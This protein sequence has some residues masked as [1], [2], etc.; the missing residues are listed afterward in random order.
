[1]IGEIIQE[2]LVGLGVTIDKPGF[3]QLN[4]TINEASSTIHTATGSWSTDFLKASTIIATALASVTTAAA[5]VMKATA[6]QD[7]AMEKLARRMM[8]SKDAAWEMKEATDA[9]GESVSDIIITPELMERYQKLVADGRNMKVGGDFAATMRGFRDL[10]FEFTR[11]KQEV[12]YALTWVGYYLL[13]YLNRP[14]A[15]AQARFRSFND[16]FIRN[17]AAWTEKLA[18]AAVY[19]INIGLHFFDLI[20]S[21]TSS[22]YDMWAAFPKGI[23]IATAAIAAF[24]AV[25]KMSPLGRMITLVSTL[26]LLVDD[27]FGYFE[28]KQA[29][30]GKYWDMLSAGLAK[31]KQMVIELSSAMGDI[32][33]DIRSSDTFQ[34]FVDVIIR[35]GKALYTLGSGGISTVVKSVRMLIDALE[36]HEA[37]KKFANVL[38]RLGRIISWLTRAVQRNTEVLDGWLGELEQSETVKDFFDAVS[39]LVSAVLDLADALLELVYTALRAFFGSMDTTEPVYGF[40]DAVRA[41]VKIITMMV[42]VLSFVIKLLAKFF[43][44]MASN[45]LFRDFWD[46]LGR[47]VKTFGSIIDTVVEGAIKRLGKLG[48]ALACLV[49]GDF[50]GAKAALF[51]GSGTTTPGVGNAGESAAEMAEYL[52]ANGIPVTAAIGIMGNIGGESSYDPSA[53]NSNDS[54]GYPSGGLAQWHADRFDRLQDFAANRGTNW[55]DRKTQLD[56]LIYELQTDYA[57]VLE[58]M[59]NASS[60]EEATEIFLR[61]FEKPRYPDDVLPER[62]DNAREV[63]EEVKRRANMPKPKLPS[64]EG[65]SIYPSYP[66]DPYTEILPTPSIG[67]GMGLVSMARYA[68]R[69]LQRMVSQA[70]PVLLN[71]IGSGMYPARYGASSHNVTYRVDVGGVTVAQTNASP[72]QIGNAVAEASMQ[73]LQQRGQYLLQN[74]TLT[75]GPNVV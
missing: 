74:R 8:V 43:K 3:Q 48:R 69:G 37:A 28:G 6:G 19:I 52:I 26:L 71:G 30:F 7:L 60:I 64:I 67:G 54:D 65:T 42:R 73:A 27:Y 4:A 51:G 32:A 18:R 68:R 12:S 41:V 17:M 20:K 40:R 66:D 38:E 45:Q 39:E 1:M 24:F 23:K 62:I 29:L 70:D 56:Y 16:S 58:Q 44:M 21:I 25:L 59:K 36:R 49:K 63:A 50:E 34:I 57:D 14:L 9:L 15:E 22:I 35:L 10:M 13:K 2:Y 33:D 47:A 46:G 72:Q 11:L 5:G 75:G 61:G 53:Y 55:R 31:A